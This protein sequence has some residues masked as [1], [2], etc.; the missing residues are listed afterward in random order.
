MSGGAINNAGDARQME[1]NKK[2]VGV[3]RLSWMSPINH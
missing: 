2:I 3:Q 1:K